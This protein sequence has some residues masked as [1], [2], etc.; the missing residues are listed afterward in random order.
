METLSGVERMRIVGGD[1]ALDYV[2]T[3]SGPPDGPPDDDVLHGYE[4]VVAWASYVGMLTG[5]EAARLGRQASTEPDEAQA[6]FRRALRVRDDLDALFRAAPA[7][8]RPSARHLGR[9]RDDTAEAVAHARLVPA[10]GGY[11]WRWTEPRDLG[12]PLWPVVHAATELLTAGPL[13]RIKACAGCRFLFV[14]ESKNRSRRWCSMD[15][16]GTAAKIRRYVA[17]RAASQRHALITKRV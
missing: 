11:R 12:R 8:G 2:N 15:D 4:D 13:D 5:S 3:R 16:C 1:L 14:D 10:E 6:V 17:R 7:G 9:L